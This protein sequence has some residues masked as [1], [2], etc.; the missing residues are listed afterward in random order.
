MLKAAGC[1][2]ALPPFLTHIPTASPYND[3]VAGVALPGIVVYRDRLQ[4]FGP[5][6]QLWH[7]RISN[8]VYGY[9]RYYS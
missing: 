4:K 9:G 3:Y 8:E 2:N 5:P 6:D 1:H 7:R